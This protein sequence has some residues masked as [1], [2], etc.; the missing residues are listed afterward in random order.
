MNVFNRSAL[1]F[2]PVALFICLCMLGLT[3]VGF[4]LD[5]QAFEDYTTEIPGT[6][7]MLEMV[8]I[9]GDDFTM[10]SPEDEAGRSGDEGPQRQVQVDSY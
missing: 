9:P 4:T 10:G 3:W 7:I 2:N 6:E 5:G 8:A 1:L